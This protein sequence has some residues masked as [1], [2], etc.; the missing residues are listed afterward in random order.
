MR[1]FEMRRCCLAW[2]DYEKRHLKVYLTSYILY[3]PYVKNMFTNTPGRP[4]GICGSDPGLATRTP[5]PPPSYFPASP[6]PTLSPNHHTHPHTKHPPPIPQ[7][8]PTPTPPTNFNT[9]PSCRPTTTS[10]P[11][12]NNSH[13]SHP[14]TYTKPHIIL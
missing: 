11:S 5:T 6:T 10:K 13:N 4:E 8:V 12:S 2:G 7:P 14:T 1:T 9:Y 3:V